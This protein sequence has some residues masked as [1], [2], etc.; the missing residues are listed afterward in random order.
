MDKKALTAICGMDCFNCEVYEEN[1][2]A[3]PDRVQAIAAKVGVAPEA[4]SCKGCRVQGCLSFMV[5]H[6][7]ATRECALARGVRWCSDCADFPCRMLAPLADQAGRLPHN[8]KLYN[9]CRIKQIGLDRWIEE[10]GET[11]RRYFT[12]KLVVGKGQAD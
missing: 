1:V 7:C 12:H 5:P 8:F 4:V 9:L 10:A 11:R 2:A 6:G 3:H